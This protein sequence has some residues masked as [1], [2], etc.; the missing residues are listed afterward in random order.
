MSNE[1]KGE[2]RAV[3]AAPNRRQFLA[4]AGGLA[5]G[6]LAIK[7]AAPEPL[8]ATSQAEVP[9]AAA[10][11]V[12]VRDVAQQPTTRYDVTVF[13]PGSRQLTSLTNGV[14]AMKARPAS[15]PTSWAYQANIHAIFCDNPPPGTTAVHYSWRFLPW[16]RAYLFYLEKIL[17]AASGDTSFSLP[18]WNWS[19]DLNLPA[20]YWGQGNPLF[21]PTRQVGPGDQVDP[22]N[23]EITTLLQIGTFPRFGGEEQEGNAGSL[24]VGPHNYVHGWVGGD[25]G[26]FATAALDPIFWAH[27]ANVD[28][29]WYLWNQEGNANPTDNAWLNTS[30]PFYD[31]D[32]RATVNVPFSTAQALPVTYAPTPPQVLRVSDPPGQQ[33]LATPR[34]APAV[35]IP[36][37]VVSRVA[38]R[39]ANAG[40]TLRVVGLT[41]PTEAPV[42][43]HVFAQR[44][45][46]T[47][48]T[49]TSD[50]GF[51]GSFTLVPTGPNHGRH[52]PV[53]V[54]VPL[55]GGFHRALAANA[56]A[57]EGARVSFTLV[58]T[59]PRGAGAPGR[60]SFDRLELHVP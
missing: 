32:Q 7:A 14:A 55:R 36:A 56:A 44:P 13:T 1:T 5:G 2:S 45:G 38:G 57:G 9:A 27:H 40:A 42:T 4:G 46:A 33:A 29:V 35:T 22:S 10:P 34:T 20:Q 51:A 58:P 47:R 59:T 21:D 50:P 49:A 17:R 53:N 8:H 3:E 48:A 23:T 6:L 31:I 15:D 24:E 11:Y 12:R 39:P 25:M 26:Q 30:Y 19:T 52:G 41:V 18:Y 16:H 54:H 43:V 60:I 28:R 37:S